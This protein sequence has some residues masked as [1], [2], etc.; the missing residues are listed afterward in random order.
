MNVLELVSSMGIETWGVSS[1]NVYS[2]TDIQNLNEALHAIADSVSQVEASNLR[3]LR[4]T[5]K[6]VE[7]KIVVSIKFRDILGEV[8]RGQF[9][10]ESLDYEANIEA[11]QKE[12]ER[13]VDGVKA[14]NGINTIIR[15]KVKEE[16]GSLLVQVRWGNSHEKFCQVVEWDYWG[17]VIKLNDTALNKCIERSIN[18][19]ML[20]LIDT[21]VMETSLIEFIKMANSSIWS[22]KFGITLDTSDIAKTLTRNTL[23]TEEVLR[24][25]KEKHYDAGVQTIRSVAIVSELGKFAAILEW[26]IDYSKRSIKVG[27]IGEKIID[28]EHG[29]FISNP[30]I[31]GRVERRV[32]PSE[33]TRRSVF[34]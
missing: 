28:I 5:P 6:V 33:E 9:E 1:S 16:E 2:E 8:S 27:I 26:N 25:I 4:L 21:V 3:R 20:K 14:V 18:G 11:I 10:L 23:C 29:N 24:F 17:I 22:E 7:D 13:I 15:N 32:I 19:S 12:V 34:A 31:Y 30:Q